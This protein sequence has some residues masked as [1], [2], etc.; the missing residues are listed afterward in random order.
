MIPGRG[1]TPSAPAADFRGYPNLVVRDTN[2][3][4]QWNVLDWDTKSWSGWSVIPGRGLTPSAPAAATG[5][6]A[7]HGGSGPTTETVVV[8][9]LDNRVYQNINYFYLNGGKPAWTSLSEVPGGRA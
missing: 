2:D 1:L 6:G 5:I 4:I 9:G 8:R 3:G 7:E